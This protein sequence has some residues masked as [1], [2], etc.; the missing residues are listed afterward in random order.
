M[1]QL[2]YLFLILLIA[3]I[4]GQCVLIPLGEK[5]WPPIRS[6]SDRV[7]KKEFWDKIWLPIKSFW[8][9]VRKREFGAIWN[10]IKVLYQQ[11]Q[12]YHFQ[13][14]VK[15][16]LTKVW[17]SFKKIW[18]SFKKACIVKLWNHV[19]K[20][21]FDKCEFYR[22]IPTNL[23]MGVSAVIV[24]SFLHDTTPLM[25]IED[26]GMDWVM[27]VRQG[28]ISPKQER[29]I[30]PFAILDID[31]ETY[32]E[33]GY[34][35]ITPRDYLK[36]LIDAA[37]KAPARLIVV[38]VELP[39]RNTLV[40]NEQDKPK[41]PCDKKLLS[42][43]ELV[44]CEFIRDYKEKCCTQTCPPI[45]LVRT[46][47]KSDP[48]KQPQL[49]KSFLDDAVEKSKPYVWW[50]TPLYSA[51]GYDDVLRRWY[52][53]KSYC[54]E[55]N[56]PQMI[57]SVELL[58]ATLIRNTT[59]TAEEHLTSSLKDYQPKS[60]S[61]D[62]SSKKIGEETLIIGNFTMKVDAKQG[63]MQRIM[64]SMPWTEP[65]SL[66]TRIL[67][68]RG[69]CDAT[70]NQPI[71]QSFPAAG[72]LKNA[73]GNPSILKNIEGKVVIIGGSHDVSGEGDIHRTPLG[74]MPG[75]MVI[76][77]AIHSLLQFS[78][79]EQVGIIWKVSIEAFLIIVMT[80][81]FVWFS[82][83]FVGILISGILTVVL[84]LPVTIFL[85]KFG[86]WLDFAIPLLVVQFHHITVA[87]EDSNEKKRN[88]CNHEPAEGTQQLLPETGSLPVTK[89]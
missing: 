71:F 55:E 41:E 69:N 53:W 12:N 70:T 13:K 77:N 32:K 79:L 19:V 27:K 84:I 16:W 35:P 2:L 73:N 49:R 40:L 5:I 26:A 30:P 50:A 24:L 22:K 59:L 44:L 31:N 62:K 74:K 9:R 21:N 6:F 4:F 72:Y 38:D 25:D 60:C 7:R 43:D 48:K 17:H 18:H 85:L 46:L 88:Q 42:Q 67:C 33:W 82:G 45:I 87:F 65:T 58:A 29:S 64:Y 81:L 37:V 11:R 47:L 10:D 57:P 34:P 80:F 83:S 39:L 20:G 51:S 68:D 8:N 52:L 15:E 1:S 86:I 89:P 23:L 56:T 36:N 75:M 28:D 66:G 54:T 3:H 78:T 63:I 76:V 61:V 14:S